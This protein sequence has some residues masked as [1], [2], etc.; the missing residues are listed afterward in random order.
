MGGE[1]IPIGVARSALRFYE[2]VDAHIVLTKKSLSTLIADAT[3]EGILFLGCLSMLSDSTDE[4]TDWLLSSL[5]L[6]ST[7]FHVGQYC[8]TWQASTA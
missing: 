5:E 7:V 6:K 4:M 3:L 8:G 1:G 2:S